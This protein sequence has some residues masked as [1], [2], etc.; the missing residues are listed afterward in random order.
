MNATEIIERL[1]V[2]GTDHEEFCD[3]GSGPRVVRR[4]RDPDCAAAAALLVEWQAEIERLKR[5]I[6][7][8]NTDNYRV[9][10]IL[11]AILDADERGQGSPFA[12]A[13]DAARK[14]LEPKA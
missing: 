9:R 8:G 4:W 14:A 13:M 2:R 5:N 7:D 11:R 6:I 3:D 1:R 12:E 10:R